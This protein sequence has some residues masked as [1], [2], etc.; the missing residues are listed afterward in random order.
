MHTMVKDA[1]GLWVERVNRVGDLEWMM[2]TAA[3]HR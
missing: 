1:D 2:T 3:S